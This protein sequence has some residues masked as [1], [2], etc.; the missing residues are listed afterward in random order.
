MF[1]KGSRFQTVSFFRLEVALGLIFTVL[2][3]GLHLIHLFHGGAFWRDETSA[4]QLGLMPQLSQVW[5]K[6]GLDSFPIL[7]SLVLRGWA[8]MGFQSDFD[9]RIL[10]LLIGLALLAV[11][12]WNARQL[13]GSAP[14]VSLLLFALSPVTIRWGDSLRA[15]GLGIFFALLFLGLTWRLI[16]LRSGLAGLAATFAAVLAVQSL[17]QNAF[18]VGSICFGGLTVTLRRRDLR[19]FA[20][21]LA[22]GMPAALS[23]LP[24]RELVARAREWNVVAEAPIG[25]ARMTEVL[26]QAL[27]APNDFALWLWVIFGSAAIAAA[28][29]LL[30]RPASVSNQDSEASCFLLTATTATSVSYYVFLKILHFQTEPWYYL[31]WMAIA[32]VTLDA[33]IAR[34][35]REQWTSLFR[36][37][38]ATLAAAFLIPEVAESARTRM[39]NADLIAKYLTQVATS[40]DFVIVHPWFSAVTFNRYYSGKASWSTLPPLSDFQVQRHDF[41]KEQMERSQPLKPVLEKIESTLRGGHS[42]WVVGYLPYS[43]PPRPAP[44]LGPAGQTATGWRGGP[45]MM[46]FGMEAAYFVQTHSSRVEAIKIQLDDPVNSYENQRLARISG[47]LE[48][49]SGG[50]ALLQD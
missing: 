36:L 40:D 19:T 12:W 42:V 21:I 18:I 35:L 10:G 6:L 32:A 17:Y 5:A 31:P 2:I 34:A 14:V 30:F 46:A 7:F 11:L 33:L 15:Y 45:F 47:W 38:F 43:Q 13:S 49:S 3:I 8:W 4:I 29:I 27:S 50:V 39:T 24:Y 23:L 22:S 1:R 25:L 48:G 20:L 9:F 41:F 37:G 16:R 26:G 44:Q 28:F